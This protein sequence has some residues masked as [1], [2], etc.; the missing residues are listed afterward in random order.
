MVL[1]Q[2]TRTSPMP[3]S[4][5]DNATRRHGPLTRQSTVGVPSR[6]R[7]RRPRTGGPD[8]PIERRGCFRYDVDDLLAAL[9]P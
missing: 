5:I 7:C 1:T 6:V 9:Q 8:R 3:L 4:G 2:L